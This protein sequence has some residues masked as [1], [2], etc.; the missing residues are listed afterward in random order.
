MPQTNSP[1]TL[2]FAAPTDAAGCAQLLFDAFGGIARAHNFPLDFP[3]REL[4]DGMAHMLVSHPWL[5]GVIA[6]AEGKVVGCNFLDQ[7]DAIAG[8]GPIAVD[9]ALQCRGVGRKL[10]Q[11]VIDRGR[12]DKHPGIRLVQDAFNTASMSLYASL[13][14]DVREPLALMTGRPTGEAPQG[15]VLPVRPDD[16]SE[17]AALC[18]AVHGFDRANE[19]RDAIERFGPMLLR[20]QGK[21]VAYASAPHFWFLNHGVARSEADMFDLLLG[22]A[23]ARPEPLAL[24]LP[25]RQANFHRWSL[26]HGMRMLKPMSLM[27]MAEYHEPKGC[28]FT[29][30]AY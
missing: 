29:S 19:L 8:V 10:M 16:I 24:L 12:A 7:R 13:G 15:D 4:T 5:F 20:K 27:T 14:F 23:A 22:I 30:V 2:R 3:K 26:S 9:P 28:Y 1:V 6:E 21:V 25:P 18:R 11:A 17:C